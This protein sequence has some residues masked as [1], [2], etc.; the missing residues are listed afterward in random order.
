MSD[1]RHETAAVAAVG[2]WESS[3]GC[4]ISTPGEKIWFLSFHGDIMLND[5]GCPQNLTTGWDEG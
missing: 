3:G 1:F 2:E 5:A 4:R